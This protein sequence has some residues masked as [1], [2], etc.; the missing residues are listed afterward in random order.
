MKN[1]M[2]SETNQYLYKG[3]DK[4]SMAKLKIKDLLVKMS[5]RNR[6]KIKRLQKLNQKQTKNFSNIKT[7]G[8][9]IGQTNRKKKKIL[10]THVRN[11]IILPEIIGKK[12]SI[13]NGIT[14]SNI[15]LKS[16]MIGKYLGEYA[17]TYKLVK[18]GSPGI[19]A[20]HSSRFI[21]LK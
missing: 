8:K 13:H 1:R 7:F 15:F 5:S 9:K 20:T 11:F 2:N 6:R 21:P 12:L 10:K 3:I 18:H 14:F 4:E 16:S 17:L 19:G